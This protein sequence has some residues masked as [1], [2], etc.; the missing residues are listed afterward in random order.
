M[1]KMVILMFALVMNATMVN[2]QR[3][4][5]ENVRRGNP[6]EQVVKKEQHKKN[7]IQGNS[8]ERIAKRADQ[9]AKEMKLERHTASRFTQIYKQYQKERRQLRKS[10][11][12]ENKNRTQASKQNAKRQQKF[13]KLDAKYRKQFARIL[14][15]QQVAY[16]MN[17]K[18][19]QTVPRGVRH[20]IH[21]RRSA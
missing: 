3:T 12:Q 6:T 2:A 16:V 5:Q 19:H 10:L 7:H 1:K 18:H 21:G 9:L 13:E 4:S 15:Q 14:N 11:A 8:T 20:E 17:H